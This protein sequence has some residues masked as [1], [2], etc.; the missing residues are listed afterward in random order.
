MNH[1]HAS[2]VE[3]AAGTEG[4]ASSGD[5]GLDRPPSLDSF[6]GRPGGRA[7]E[8]LVSEASSATTDAS[9][10]Q[11]ERNQEQQQPAVSSTASEASLKA[12]GAGM[13]SN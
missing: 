8:L 12:A 6:Q 10:T 13:A 7:R 11:Q 5:D 1:T 3:E 4:A 9:D 2:A